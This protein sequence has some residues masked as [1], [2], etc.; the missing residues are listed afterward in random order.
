VSFQSREKKRRYKAAE[1]KAR[2]NRTLETRGRWFLTLAKKPGFCMCCGGP[3]GRGAE[4]VFRCEP[5]TLRCVP[6]ADRL[7]DSKS[8]RP[9]LRWDR[10][11]PKAAKAWTDAS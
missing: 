9:S 11:R 8:Y 7:E 6:C 3:F 5:R 2:R 4:I 10:A 1:A